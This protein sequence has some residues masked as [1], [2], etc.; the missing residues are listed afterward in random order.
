MTAAPRPRTLAGWLVPALLSVAA[1]AAAVL[2]VVALKGPAQPPAPVALAPV[3]LVFEAAPAAMPAAPPPEP[4]IAAPPPSAPAKAAA[5]LQEENPV[6]F[7]PP[8]PAPPAAA[9]AERPPPAPRVKPVPPPEPAPPS[10]TKPEPPA[11][12]APALR[13]LAEGAAPKARP[14]DAGEGPA[15]QSASL[16]TG[17]V[18]AAAPAEAASAPPK[19]SAPGYGH[20]ALGNPPPRYPAPARR[21]GL[22]G[23]VLLRVHVE[24]DGTADKVEV[25]ESSG[26]ALLDRAARRA[27]SRW[28]FTPAK[29]AGMP[30]SGTVD[31]PVAFRLKD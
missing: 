31:V 3:E 15:P 1:H 16:P 14:P 8:E 12:A 7:A 23:S 9:R 19:P 6:S 17:T 30:V 26:H 27:V 20:A 25:L 2:G 24:A 10:R 13:S 18:P 11:E 21:R 22:E 29:L 28:R 4:A 5:P